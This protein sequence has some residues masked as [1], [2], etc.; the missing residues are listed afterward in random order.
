MRQ[1][2]GIF[3]EFNRKSWPK[4]LFRSRFSVLGQAPRVVK[5]NEQLSYSVEIPY[6]VPLLLN[7]DIQNFVDSWF[8]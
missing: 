7:I 6:Y 4:G 1:I 5:V 8:I 2:L 3:N